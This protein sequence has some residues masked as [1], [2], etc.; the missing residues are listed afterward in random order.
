[1][2]KAKFTK[3]P[4]MIGVNYEINDSSAASNCIANV[5]IWDQC[6]WVSDANLNLIAA[7]PEMYDSIAEIIDLR[8]SNME[9]AV[10]WL[11]DNTDDLI[12]LL[13]KARGE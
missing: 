6:P 13:A 4:W 11:L 7:A 2:S 1:M 10:Q 3:G 5:E 8:D 9:Y 12:N